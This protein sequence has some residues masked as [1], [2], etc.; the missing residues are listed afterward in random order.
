MGREDGATGSGAEE[1]VATNGTVGSANGAVS[2][3]EEATTGAA[4]GSSNK[5]SAGEGTDEES[6][7]TGG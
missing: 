7:C 1:D 4:G 3:D 5:A 6:G 2:V